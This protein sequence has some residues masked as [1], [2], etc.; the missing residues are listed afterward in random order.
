[1]N[2][3]TQGFTLIELLVVIA[4]IGVLA[5]ILLPTFSDA[6]KRPNDTAALQCGR[7]IVAFQVT[8]NLTRGSYASALTDM[9]PDVQESC[10]TA[11]VSVALN[12]V[13]ANNPGA[14]VSQ[15]VSTSATN[16]AFQVFHPRGTGYYLFN[17]ESAPSTGERLN[18]LYRW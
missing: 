18:R 15:A 14:G 3:R 4:I 13:R 16:Y 1:M 10:T 7:A 9:G 17:Q 11:G 6:Q 8:A 12:N 2:P 5:A